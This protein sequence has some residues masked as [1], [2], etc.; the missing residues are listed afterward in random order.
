[1]K[2]EVSREAY[3]DYKRFYQPYENETLSYI[4]DTKKHAQEIADAGTMAGKSFDTIQ[5][6]RQ[7]N[8]GRMGIEQTTETKAN[9]SKDAS[10]DK[11]LATIDTKNR[12]R[13]VIGQRTTALSEEMVG[14]GKGIKSDFDN[15]MSSWTQLEGMNNQAEAQK[16]AQDAA[17][18][19][20]MIGTGASVAMMAVAAYMA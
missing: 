12:M 8:Q 1:M 17:S 20:Q 5:E 2:A 19:N 3:E 11:A 15:T 18:R 6:S 7:R 9:L 16:K 10:R 13:D 4:G 14:I